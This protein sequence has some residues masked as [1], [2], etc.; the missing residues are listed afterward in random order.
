MFR[1]PPDRSPQRSAIKRPALFW[2]ILAGILILLAITVPTDWTNSF[3]SLLGEE[4]PEQLR[5]WGDRVDAI[6]E[7]LRAG[8]PLELSESE[9]DRLRPHLQVR[10][11]YEAGPLNVEDARDAEK[12][13]RDFSGRIERQELEGSKDALRQERNKQLARELPRLDKADIDR[14]LQTLREQLRA[15]TGS[16]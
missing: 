3:S 4:K 15:S 10:R 6:D 1:E 16:E 11:L 5:P 2:T 12:I 8:E 13:F 14:A 9:L 7:T